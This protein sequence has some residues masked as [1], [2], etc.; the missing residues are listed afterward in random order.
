MLIIFRANDD[1]DSDIEPV[2]LDHDVA[3]TFVVQ[4][5]E[6]QLQS[7]GITLI[8]AETGAPH[9]RKPKGTHGECAFREEPRLALPRIPVRG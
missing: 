8:E 6:P 3:Q 1:L 5:A 4:R 9:L 7:P 2:F